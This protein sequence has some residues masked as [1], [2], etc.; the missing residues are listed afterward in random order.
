M[1]VAA[2][3]ARTHAANDAVT[4]RRAFGRTRDDAD[5]FYGRHASRMTSSSGIAK[6]RLRF[7]S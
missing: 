3:H 7:C 2:E 5:V 6:P 1:R 4:E